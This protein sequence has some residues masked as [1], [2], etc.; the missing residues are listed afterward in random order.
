MSKVL[1]LSF[2][3]NKVKTSEEIFA[4]EI[5][6]MNMKINGVEARYRKELS[7]LKVTVEK[8]SRRIMQLEKDLY[9]EEEVKK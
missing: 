5:E 1:P 4:E 9:I 6:R 7:E 3:L 2:S 8:Q